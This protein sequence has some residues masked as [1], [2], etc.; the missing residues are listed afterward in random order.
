MKKEN[1]LK[2]YQSYRTSGKYSCTLT[3]EAGTKSNIC[4]YTYLF[5][6]F[7]FLSEKVRETSGNFDKRH[8]WQ[9]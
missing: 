6:E 4:F 3:P 8:R 7:V 2:T 5:R 9:T 1:L